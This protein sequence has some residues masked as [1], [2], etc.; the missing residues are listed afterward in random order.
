MEQFL[1]I[2]KVVDQKVH[3]L[4]HRFI[5]ARDAAHAEE[6]FKNY[7]T[8]RQLVNGYQKPEIDV[9]YIIKGENIEVL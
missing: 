7:L 6:V 9:E 3:D 2:G 8:I 4:E 1:V 5:L